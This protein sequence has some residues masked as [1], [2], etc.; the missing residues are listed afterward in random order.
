MK[1]MY[2]LSDT[3][4]SNHVCD[5]CQLDAD[6]IETAIALKD[7]ICI[8]TEWCSECENEV[9]MTWDT[10]VSGYAAFCPHCGKRLMLCD[11]CKHSEDNSTGICDWS[12]GADGDGHCFRIKEVSE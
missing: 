8:V 4:N 11:E 2:C 3:R 7:R 1:C 6:R 9:E 12:E 5:A 10:D